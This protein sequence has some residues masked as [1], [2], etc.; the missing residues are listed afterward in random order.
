MRS[1][2]PTTTLTFLFTDIEGSTQ[3]WETHP[4]AMKA[5]MAKHDAIL[6]AAIE[7]NNGHVIKTT[8]DG[9]HAV[10]STALDA[11]R[12]SLS[13]QTQLRAPLADLHIKV[14]IGLHT[15]EAEL[16]AGDYYGQTPNRAARIMSLGMAGRSSSPP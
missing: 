12:S 16:R 3:L 15:G 6:R 7:S 13:L 5:A 4:E 2:L 1:I 11:V 9:F 14:R 8:G 10:F